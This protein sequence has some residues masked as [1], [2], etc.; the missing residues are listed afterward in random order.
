MYECLVKLDI[1]DVCASYKFI[2]IYFIIVLT[3]LLVYCLGNNECSMHLDKILELSVCKI[4]TE[5]HNFQ[6][7]CL[8]FPR[9][10][11]IVDYKDKSCS[12]NVAPYA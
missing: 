4:V 8:R 12:K 11:V 7:N 9:N 2:F 10:F 5:K 3:I 6:I 1:I